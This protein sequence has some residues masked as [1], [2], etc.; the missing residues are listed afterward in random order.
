M[1]KNTQLIWNC[2]YKTFR[3]IA[4]SHT[5]AHGIGGSIVQHTKGMLGSMYVMKRVSTD[6]HLTR[7]S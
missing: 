3:T 7:V 1:E 4:V 6:K 2:D 5:E